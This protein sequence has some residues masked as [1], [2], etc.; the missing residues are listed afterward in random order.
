MRESVHG[1][2]PRRRSA[3][4]IVDKE[5]VK[6]IRILV[7]STIP[8]EGASVRFRIYQFI[9][10]L[11]ASGFHVTVRPFYTREFFK[12][13]YQPGRYFCKVLYFIQEAVN[14]L[15]LMVKKEDFDLFLVHREAVPLGPPIIEMALAGM[16]RRAL[17]YDFDDAIYLPNV[18]EANRL[19][20]IMKWPR[21]VP[22]IIRASDWVMAGNEYLAQYAR[23]Y[24]NSVTMIPTCVDTRKFVP[25]EDGVSSQEVPIVGWIGSPTTVP[26]LLGLQKVLARVAASHRFLLRVSGSVGALAMPGVQVANVPWSLKEEVSLFNTCDI[27]IYPLWDDPWTRGKCGFKAIQFMA[28]GVPVVAAAVGVNR[29][30]IQDGVNGFL[31]YSEAEWEEKVGWLLSVPGLGEKLGRAGRETIMERYSLAIQA[32]LLVSTLRGAIEK[33][34]ISARC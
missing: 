29:E 18:S 10:A 26:Y 32:P 30:I 17:V 1:S 20:G 31:A 3:R 9:P 15:R 22:D 12:I 27:G 8:E 7:L 5:P 33:V 2:P 34:K 25:R 28:C 19:L 4:A 16:E 13:L 23:S 6:P 21:K 14:R 11:E 24:N